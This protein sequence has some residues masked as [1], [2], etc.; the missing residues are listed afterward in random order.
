M[1]VAANDAAPKERRFVEVGQRGDDVSDFTVFSAHQVT[2]TLAQPQI[3]R[4]ARG[5]APRTASVSLPSARNG[6][7]RARRRSAAIT[8]SLKRPATARCRRSGSTGW[9]SKGRRLRSTPRR[10]RSSPPRR[11]AAGA[12]DVI[13]RFATRAF[14]GVPPVGRLSR[15]ACGIVRDAPQHGRLVRR[16]AQGAAQRR[17]RLAGFPLSERAVGR[18]GTSPA[19]Q[20]RT[21]QRGSPI[22]CGAGRRTTSC[23]RSPAATPCKSPRC[24]PR[25][26]IA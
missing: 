18:G 21:R 9:K 13:E 26:W 25:K 12:R 5:R 1:R 19:R 20:F 11:I 24:S 14:R 2:G 7:I 10:C 17:A 3:D 23:S 8:T 22:S 6:R 4:A 16:G 15:P